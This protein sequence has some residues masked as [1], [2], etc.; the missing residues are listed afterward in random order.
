VIVDEAW[1]GKKRYGGQ[2]IV[3]GGIEKDTKRL[4]LQIIPDTEQDSL[5]DFLEHN[6][7]RDSLVVTDCGTGYS[8][9]E[10]L[11]YTREAWNHSRGHFAGTNY[12]EQVWSA[13]KRYLR[14]LYGCIP[15][16]R[17]QLILNEWMARHNNRQL[18][19]LPQNYLQAT[20]TI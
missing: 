9:I 13:M 12:I 17:L 14:K 5:E 11:G 6:V 10:W 2:T 20:L 8:G 4:K 18:F 1:F 15:T 7:T 3:I 16:K 19:V